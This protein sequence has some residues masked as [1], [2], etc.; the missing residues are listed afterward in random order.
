MN[1]LNR[2]LLASLAGLALVMPTGA[3]AALT[4]EQVFA[5]LKPEVR[6]QLQAGEIVTL[7]RPE[8]ETSDSGLAVSLA[9]IV[10]ADL[11]KTVT[12]FRTLNMKDAAEQ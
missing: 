7:A 1:R 11:N 5:S 2:W 6:K 3:H 12:T 10:P 8:Q 9:V 4:A